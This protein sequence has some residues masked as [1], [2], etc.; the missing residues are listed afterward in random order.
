MAR[1]RDRV[2]ELLYDGEAVRESIELGDAAVVVTSHR[3][4]AFTPEMDGA[5]FRAVDRPNVVGVDAGARADGDLLERGI[6][7][8][9]IGA[10]LLIAGL[11]VDFGAIVGS[12]DLTGAGASGQLGLGGVLGAVQGL[13]DVLR[14]LDRLLRLFGG[15]A[16]LLAAVLLGVYWYQREPTLVVE[17]AGDEDIHVPRPADGKGA[18]DRLERAIAAGDGRAEP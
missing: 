15:L 16:V 5:N 13:L 17:V 8:G 9:V 6:R 14:D 11:V 7:Y 4:L 3:V 18:S 10:V 1:W 2:E 12:V